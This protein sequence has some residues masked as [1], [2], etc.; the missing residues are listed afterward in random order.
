MVEKYKQKAGDA[1]TA[2][3]VAEGRSRYSDPKRAT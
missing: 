1:F 3:G 2:K